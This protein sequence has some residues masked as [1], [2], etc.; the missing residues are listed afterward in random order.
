MEA[1]P[2]EEVISHWFAKLRDIPDDVHLLCPKTR[3][4]DE[5]DYTS[6][7]GADEKK[8]KRIQEGKDRVQI[9]YWCSLV[10][11]MPKEKYEAQVKELSNR[12]G[13]WLKECNQCIISWHM[14]R[15]PFLQ[16][17]AE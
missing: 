17:F 2:I 6:V 16:E 13:R 5:E 7:V 15:K 3:P 12:L 9:A 1:R 14:C 11:G 4:Y 10:F 8:K